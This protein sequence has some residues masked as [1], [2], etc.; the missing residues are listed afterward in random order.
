VVVGGTGTLFRVTHHY[1]TNTVVIDSASEDYN[2]PTVGTELEWDGTK[3]VDNGYPAELEYQGGGIS[4]Y[5]FT[6]WVGGYGGDYV[7]MPELG[8]SVFPK[9]FAAHAT[10]TVTIDYDR[11]TVTNSTVLAS[12]NDIAAQIDALNLGTM[13]EEDAGD[14]SKSNELATV[15]HTGEYDDLLYTPTM[16]ASNP[17]DRAA[18]VFGVDGVGWDGWTLTNAS[19][20]AGGHVVSTSSDDMFACSPGPVVTGLAAIAINYDSS[21]GQPVYLE[22]ST[23]GVLWS[24]PDYM[25]K[26]ART[27]PLWLRFSARSIAT[28]P[29]EVATVAVERVTCDL[30]RDNN[31]VGEVF[32]LHG[33]AVQV[34]D[35]DDPLDAANRNYVDRVAGRA[36]DDATQALK[37]W[38]QR[39]EGDAHLNGHRL[40]LGSNW[41]ILGDADS[42]AALSNDGSVG[43]GVVGDSAQ[44][45]I[46]L[47]NENVLV[48]RFDTSMMSIQDWS[49]AGADMWLTVSTNGLPESP[50]EAD[51]WVEYT[52]DLLSGLW[53][54]V[55]VQSN[56]L[57][58]AAATFTIG[59]ANP[60]WGTSPQGYFRVMRQANNLAALRTMVPLRSPSI[61]V[62]ASNS[63]AVPTSEGALVFESIGADPA[64]IADHAQLY[65]VAGEMWAMDADGNA[66]RL[67]THDDG[68]WVATS[69]NLYTG[70]G[71]SVDMLTGE[72]TRY[73]LPASQRRDWE[74]DQAA[75][76]AR[77]RQAIRLWDNADPAHRR[78]V[79]P[80]PYTP[81][82]IP[83]WIATQREAKTD[84]TP[85]PADDAL[86][87]KD[88]ALAAL[89]GLAAGATGGALSRIKKRKVQA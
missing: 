57:P 52:D 55:P 49:G 68:A 82:P 39:A 26:V 3:Y 2:G 16:L 14:Y 47:A 41:S 45:S 1:D 75:I 88:G 83:Q 22:A 74:A 69:V 19:I 80:R 4:S 42:W 50:A 38:E 17:I 9:T 61:M 76:A 58:V 40:H 87:I 56:D 72:R 8:E 25:S 35:P 70:W 60:I 71:T 77:V 28:I 65:A 54:K 51:A 24:T 59:F 23:N 7:V 5:V 21:L 37:W 15:A 36:Q 29:D 11:W 73:R 85:I 67:T 12:T 46:Q 20:T 64:G 79:R 89:A 31:R 30:W 18:V 27:L 78:E 48:A 81:R 34:D 84:P 13:A 53:Y 63:V 43:L 86:P 33:V 6:Y 10:G 62:S 32:P 66:T 44:F